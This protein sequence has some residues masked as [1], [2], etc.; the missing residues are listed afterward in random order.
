MELYKKIKI[1]QNGNGTYFKTNLHT[2]H[3]HIINLIVQLRPYISHLS[4]CLLKN[5][6]SCCVGEFTEYSKKIPQSY[7]MDFVILFL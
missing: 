5:K 3:I 1:E 6:I 7:I 2:T 4:Q